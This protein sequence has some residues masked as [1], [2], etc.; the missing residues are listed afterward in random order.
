LERNREINKC[1]FWIEPVALAYD[2]ATVTFSIATNHFMHGRLH[3]V[4]GKLATVPTAT[5]RQIIAKY[6]F[7]TVNLISNSEGA[8]IEMVENDADI[9]RD[10]VKTIIIETHANE[11][12]HDLVSKMMA[13]L[14]EIGFRIA[15]QRREM[16]V[17]ALI[18]ARLDPLGPLSG[19]V[20][21]D[22]RPMTE[23]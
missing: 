15:E 22:R 12:G 3:A 20:S 7:E 11:R 10:H 5:L 9:L 17:F 16:P 21:A 13:R 6:K 2:A 4:E 18:N 19:A 1:Q 8:E 23:P 14:H